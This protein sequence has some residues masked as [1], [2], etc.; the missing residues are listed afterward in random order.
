MTVVVVSEWK[1][2]PANYFEEA[3]EISRHDYAMMISDGAV[4]AKIDSAKGL[5]RCFR[6][7]QDIVGGGH[8]DDGDAEE[9]AERAGCVGG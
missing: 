5:Y 1:F 3:I 9:G 6:L 2:S 4:Q 7:D 8:F